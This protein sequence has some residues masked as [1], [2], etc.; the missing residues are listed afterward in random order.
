MLAAWEGGLVDKPHRTSKPEV[1]K[2]IA[3]DDDEPDFDE[4]D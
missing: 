3:E 1:A 2:S 4:G